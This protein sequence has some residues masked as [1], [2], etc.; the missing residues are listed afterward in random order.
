MFKPTCLLLLIALLVPV[1][2]Q[3]QRSATGSPG[4]AAFAADRS[5]GSFGWGGAY[6]SSYRVDPDARLTMLLMIHLLPGTSDITAKSPTL[7][8]Q[9]LV[10][11]TKHVTQ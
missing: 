6:G 3:A 5:V 2:S 1:S 8:Y 9:A 4:Q 10:E 11:S 7:V